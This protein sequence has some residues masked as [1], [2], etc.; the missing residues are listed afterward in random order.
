MPRSIFSLFVDGNLVEEFQTLE[1][2][3]AALAQILEVEPHLAES[4]GVVEY[5][6]EQPAPAPTRQP[7][8]A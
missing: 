4:S 1:E 8:R 6:D 5:R 2:A 7:A 3:D